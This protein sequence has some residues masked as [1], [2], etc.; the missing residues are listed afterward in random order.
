V[1]VAACV[2]ITILIVG[3]ARDRA[4]GPQVVVP[5]AALAPVPV[6]SRSVPVTPST[7]TQGA[8]ASRG[9]HR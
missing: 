3:I 8:A 1:L 4:S 9:G 6:D 7:E 2:A 5:A